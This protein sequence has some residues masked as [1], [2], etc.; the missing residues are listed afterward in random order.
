MLGSCKTWNTN[1]NQQRMAEEKQNVE[2][3]ETALAPEVKEAK[4]PE[5]DP[6]E[7]LENFDWDKYEEYIR[8]GYIYTDKGNVFYESY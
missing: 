7:F 2:V 6:Q 5:Q 4:Q 3:E 8:D 1:F